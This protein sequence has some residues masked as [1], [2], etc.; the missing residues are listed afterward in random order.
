M[1]AGQVPIFNLA[2][3]GIAYF[4]LEVTT[5][6]R[7][8]HSGVFGGAALNAAHTLSRVVS[9]L[10]DD[11]GLPAAQLCVGVQAPE[12]AEAQ[13]WRELPDGL[14]MLAAE[15]GAPVSAT[16]GSEFYRRTW[17]LPAVDVHS[18]RAG[19]DEGLKTI[20]PARARASLSVRLAPGQKVAEVAAA[21]EEVV[22]AA[23]P[24]GA[25]ASLRLRASAEPA[26]VPG[27]S[28][29]VR[30]ALDAFEAALG[31]RPRLG[32]S[33]GSLPV[34]GVLAARGIPAIVTGFDLPEGNIHAANERL[35]VSHVSAGVAAAKALL[36]AFGSLAAEG[37]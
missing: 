11:D 13:G 29:A 24:Q 1:L 10:V 33:G 2:T 17:A 31:I 25:Q 37:D 4:D 3:R 32:R 23:L 19:D 6:E 20:V 9:A 26:V 15:G 12:T 36:V 27:S 30:L 21:L 35:R 16:A 5:G 14:E 22:R 28:P 8:L 18:V 7:D 34:L